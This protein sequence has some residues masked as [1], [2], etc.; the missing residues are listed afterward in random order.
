MEREQRHGE[1]W[2]G[3]GRDVSGEHVHEQTRLSTGAVTDNNKLSSNLGHGVACDGRGVV[4][5]E[6]CRQRG[7]YLDGGLAVIEVGQQRLQ[8]VMGG[9][10]H[11]RNGGRAATTAAELLPAPRS[12][13]VIAG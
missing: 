11:D 4:L 9:G 8:G 6:I 13:F 1:R 3:H 2:C 5:G 10:H 7:E 12:A